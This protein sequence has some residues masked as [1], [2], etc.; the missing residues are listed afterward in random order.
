MSA[1]AAFLRQSLRLLARRVAGLAAF[2]GIFLLAGAVAR[3]LTGGEHGHVEMDPLF[4]LGGTTLVSGLILVGWLIGRFPMIAILVLASGV[5]SEDLTSGQA[6]LYA[7]R[8][9]SLPLLYG[10]RLLLVAALAFL[11]S[12][13]VL[14]AFDLLVIGQWTGNSVFA[15]ILA[16]IL[17]YG[18][19]TAL[20]SVLTRGDAWIALF[21]G[22][23]ALVWD[24]LRRMDFLQSAPQALRETISVLLPP[25]GALIRVETAFGGGQPVPWDAMLYIALYA[26]LLLV[27]AG[28]ALSRREL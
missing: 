5:F 12:I 15:L 24:A 9:H 19:V 14:P 11:L 1:I 8:P 6:R 27:I 17:V 23:L 22:I 18:S 3:V 7:V 13:I 20:L 2:G 26:A 28:V 25:Q 21:L 16:Q 4:Q 10:A